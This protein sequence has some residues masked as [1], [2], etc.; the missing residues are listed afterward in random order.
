MTSLKAGRCAG[1]ADPVKP[2]GGHR[3]GGGPAG[4]ALFGS[5]NQTTNHGLA[6]EAAR[7][8]WRR[9]GQARPAPRW[10]MSPWR[11]SAAVAVARR[12]VVPALWAF[13]AGGRGIG[14]RIAFCGWSGPAGSVPAR[15]RSVNLISGCDWT[16]RT[17]WTG[18]PISPQLP[19]ARWWCRW[20]AGPAAGLHGLRCHQ[21]GLLQ[22]AD[23]AV[24][25]R[26]A[27][28]P[29]PAYVPAGRGGLC[30]GESAGRVLADRCEPRPLGQ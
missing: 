4:R 30:D 27:N 19:C 22:A 17:C 2:A 14:W 18:C 26:P 23:R 21:P 1:V 11:L 7:N 28:V 12:P 16:S 13:G 6:Q 29:G 20:S 15:S 5:H 3:T 8:S 24:D 10:V 25:D 9:G